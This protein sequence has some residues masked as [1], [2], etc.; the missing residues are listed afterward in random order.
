MKAYTAEQKPHAPAGGETTGHMEST[1]GA[2]HAVGI[3]ESG[4]T[5]E[6]VYSGPMAGP[7]GIP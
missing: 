4:I 5:G 1:V 6:G 2:S 3:G 7:D